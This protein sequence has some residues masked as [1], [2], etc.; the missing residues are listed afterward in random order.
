MDT[1]FRSPLYYKKNTFEA[2]P[3][4]QKMLQEQPNNLYLKKKRIEIYDLYFSFKRNELAYQESLDILF[5][6]I[7]FKKELKDSCGLSK[8]YRNL[9]GFW[10]IQ[11]DY[12]KSLPYSQEAIRIARNNK[13]HKDEVRSIMHMAVYYAAQ[14]DFKNAMKTNLEALQICL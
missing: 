5:Q 13:C 4:I 12:E 10:R 1:Y 3:L 9:G 14:Y 7:E 11:R 2:Y 6:T 8:S